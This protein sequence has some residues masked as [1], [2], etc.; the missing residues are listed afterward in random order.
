MENAVLV[1]LSMPYANPGGAISWGGEFPQNQVDFA[2]NR[3]YSRLVSDLGDITLVTATIVFPSVTGHYRYPIQYPTQNPPVALGSYATASVVFSGV[4]QLGGTAQVII[5]GTTFSYT[6]P[7][8][9]TTIAQIIAAFI[10]QINASNLVQP[11]GTI[12]SPVNQALNSTSTLSLMAGLP[13]T[14]GNAITLAV[15]AAGPLIGI[16]GGGALGTEGGAGVATESTLILTPSGATFAN[17]TAANQP[18]RTVRRVQYQALGQLFALELEPGARM[19]SWEEFNRK[20]AAG[21]LLPFSYTTWPDYCAVSTKRDTLYF[22]GAPSEYGDLITVE[23]CPIIT[24]NAAIPASA[25]GYLV[26]STDIPLL[27]EDTQ[28]AIWMGAVSFLNPKAREYEG[29]RTYMQMYKDEVQRAKDNYT[30][31]SAGDALILRPVEDAL[32]TSGYGAHIEA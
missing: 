16:E 20:T 12:L 28:D 11:A 19:L 31:D 4:V 1:A 24:S 22:Y 29:G 13:G 21:Y 9:S 32:A 14:A 6:I 8:A 15:S 17:G 26:N 2:I 27:P 7:S 30:R 10:V 23:Y 25:W 5:N 18:I 3:A